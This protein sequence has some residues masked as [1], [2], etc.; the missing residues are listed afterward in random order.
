MRLPKAAIK[1]LDAIA[2]RAYIPPRTLIRT[3]VLQRLEAERKG[4]KPAMSAELGGTSL[5]AGST[6]TP[7]GGMVANGIEH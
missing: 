3:W 5:I 6:N 7:Q 4:I 2:S 1:E